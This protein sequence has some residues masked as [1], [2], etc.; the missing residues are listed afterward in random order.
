M[1]PLAI[2]AAGA[3]GTLPPTTTARN[4]GVH[5]GPTVTSPPS[6]VL[7]FPDCM[8]ACGNTLYD[9]D[10]DGFFVCLEVASSMYI[11]SSFTRADNDCTCNYFTYCTRWCTDASANAEF[12]S[13]Y[14]DKCHNWGGMPWS[15]SRYGAEY[16][17]L[18]GTGTAVV[19]AQTSSTHLT[20]TPTPT[21]AA[22]ALVSLGAPGCVSAMNTSVQA[23]TLTYNPTGRRNCQP[24]ICVGLGR[25]IMSCSSICTSLDQPAQ[26]LAWIQSTCTKPISSLN[27]SSGYVDV[28]VFSP[29]WPDFDWYQKLAHQNLFAWDWAVAL[30]RERARELPPNCP[31]RFSKLGSFVVVNLVTLIATVIAGRRQVVHF[32]TRGFWGKLGSPWWPVI[33]LL[34]TG[35]LIGVNFINAYLVQTTPGFS[36][37]PMTEL[38]LLWLCRPRLSWVAIL[39]VKVDWENGT[40][41]SVGAA[42]VFSEVLLQALAGYY[43]V[44]TAIFA[45]TYHYYRVN[46]I[47]RAVVPSGV[48]ACTMYIGALLWCASI[49]FVLLHVVWTFL[50]L[51]AL[52]VNIWRWIRGQST[53]KLAWWYFQ[54]ARVLRLSKTTWQ[55]L[56]DEWS[57]RT[58]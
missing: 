44:R 41:V 23:F 32:I 37:V 20:D 49:G 35:L 14:R 11:H 55:I 57:R 7:A 24:S 29:G 1:L 48:S 28:D 46:F 9:S 31:S 21:N 3:V 50:G 56:F 36:S 43:M 26:Y 40:Y 18:S 34:T 16:P 39:M 33:A 4:Y 25:V 5:G 58:F 54:S 27:H 17:S 22:D 52:V 19:V 12:S 2:A 42:A 47:R 30:D 10:I 51:G 8:D 45:Q 53:E 13:W 6:T 15:W 38:A